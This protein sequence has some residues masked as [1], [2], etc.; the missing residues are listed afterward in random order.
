MLSLKKNN[1]IQEDS[2]ILGFISYDD[3]DGYLQVE[4]WCEKKDKLVGE[5]KFLFI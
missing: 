3:D 2:Q 1:G 5:F 4:E